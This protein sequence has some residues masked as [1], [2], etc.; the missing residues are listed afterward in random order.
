[1]EKAGHQQRKNHNLNFQVITACLNC[2][3]PNLSWDSFHGFDSA[4]RSKHIFP[5]FS[6]RGGLAFAQLE[7]RSIIGSKKR[8]LT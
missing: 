4:E 8:N 3:A 2:T 1:M 7:N 6:L 5:F